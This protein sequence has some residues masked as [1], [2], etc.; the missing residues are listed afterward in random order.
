MI[1]PQFIRRYPFFTGVTTEQA[2]I[3]AKSARERTFEVDHLF[4]GEGDKLNRCYLVL[5]GS[6]AI[7]LQ[8]PDR[9]SATGTASRPDQG[10]PTRDIIV[11]TVGTGDIFGWSALIPPYVATAAAKSI[12]PCQVIE[13]DMAELRLAMDGD[14]ELAHLLTLRV[15]QIIRDRLRDLRMEL[16]ADL[17]R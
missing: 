10:G 7:M 3:L 8:T 15:A 11:S 2:L 5:E 13:F 6:V 4:F 9:E 16:L 12:L 14:H 17:A 1:S